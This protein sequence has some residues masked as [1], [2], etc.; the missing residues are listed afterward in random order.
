[1]ASIRSSAWPPNACTKRC[2]I[3]I[4]THVTSGG[5]IVLSGD[6]S[7]DE[8][9]QQ[10]PEH[11]VLEAACRIGELLEHRAGDRRDE[12]APVQLGVA[13]L[14]RPEPEL[15][16]AQ[17]GGVP[18]LHHRTDALAARALDE[19]LVDGDLSGAVV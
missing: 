18:L 7:R 12:D 2:A 8:L 6:Q 10:R 16:Q 3:V 9:A 11:L 17:E 13:R 5:T 15:G 1:M 19:Q 4:R 14:P